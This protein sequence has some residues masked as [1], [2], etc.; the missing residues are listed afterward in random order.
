MDLT[1]TLPGSNDLPAWI[2]AWGTVIAIV[3]STALAIGVP[4]WI[5]HLDQR[6]YRRAIM[7][8]AGGALFHAVNGII[9]HRSGKIGLAERSSRAIKAALASLGD[10]QFVRAN[11]PLAW[12]SYLQLR[13]ALERLVDEVASPPLA[14]GADDTTLA[15][16]RDTGVGGLCRTIVALEYFVGETPTMLK[17]RK[18]ADALPYHRVSRQL[19]AEAKRAYRPLVSR[20]GKPLRSRMRTAE[21]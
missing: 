21:L 3:L 9:A 1:I 17:P 18:D 15:A 12:S 10:T 13:E 5:K 20:R 2:Q 14:N 6:Q 11:V 7:E 19:F 16:W 4:I 8:L